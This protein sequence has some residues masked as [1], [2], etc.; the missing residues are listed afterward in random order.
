MELGALTASTMNRTDKKVRF[1]LDS[2]GGGL[3][4]GERYA[5]VSSVSEE[6][7]GL[8]FGGWVGGGS[9]EGGRRVVRCVFEQ[10]VSVLSSVLVECVLP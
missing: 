3:R 9:V 4:T 5:T 8:G 7:W 10:A 1:Q 6:G 2:G